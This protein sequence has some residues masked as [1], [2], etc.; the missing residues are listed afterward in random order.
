VARIALAI[1]EFSHPSSNE[2]MMTDLNKAIENTT[3]VSGNEWKYVAELETDLDPALP[4]IMCLPGEMNQVF[5]NLIVNAAHAIGDKVC[6]NGDKG[7][8]TVSTRRDGAM[9]EIRVRDTGTGIPEAAREQV[10]DPFFTTKEVGRG[11][12][13]GLTISYDIITHKHDGRIFFETETGV[14][15]TFVIQLPI[16]SPE[17][18]GNQ[19]DG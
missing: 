9:A 7:T 14:G 5:L 15:T 4:P 12:G 16:S 17:E 19:R 1:E 3:T 18:A 2:K 10:F 6:D 11:T 8:I 13:Q